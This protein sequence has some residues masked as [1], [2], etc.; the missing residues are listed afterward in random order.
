MAPEGPHRPPR[1]LIAHIL[2]LASNEVSIEVEAPLEVPA[3]VLMRNP[4]QQCL[5]I[6]FQFSGFYCIKYC[7]EISFL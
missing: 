7:S 6:I 4:A 2:K 3:S 1:A 5:H